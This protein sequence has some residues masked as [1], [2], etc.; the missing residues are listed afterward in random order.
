[1]RKIV[2]KQHDEVALMMKVY[3]KL[4]YLLEPKYEEE[5]KKLP[6]SQK[7]VVKDMVIMLKGI[8]SMN[9]SID[10]LLEST[11]AIVEDA[12]TLERA[13][14]EL[15]DGRAL[16]EYVRGTNNFNVKRHSWH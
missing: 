4:S 10:K 13:L 5:I 2:N 1:M 15:P 3:D 12:K 7:T 6:A 11:E 9:E 16:V 14:I 8:R